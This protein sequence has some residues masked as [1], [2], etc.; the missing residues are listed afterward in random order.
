MLE[1]WNNKFTSLTCCTWLV[2]WVSFCVLS[3]VA[4][5]ECF[6]AL[7]N[8]VIWVPS[9]SR[10]SMI[11][12][13]YGSLLWKSREN[14]MMSSVDCYVFT[15]KLVQWV[16]VKANK[17]Q[18]LLCCRELFWCVIYRDGG[19]AKGFLQCV[20]CPGSGTVRGIHI[21]SWCFPLHVLMDSCSTRA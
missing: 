18:F 20:L 21:G 4:R 13:I 6:M 14:V 2:T 11:L 12:W 7:D 9:K 10:S 17:P 16:P 3:S 8:S 1:P 5:S 19:W 15:D